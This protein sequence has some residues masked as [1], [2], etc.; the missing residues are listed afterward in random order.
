MNLVASATPRPWRPRRSTTSLE[1]VNPPLQVCLLCG[2][3]SR[4]MGR[5]KALMPHPDG[6]VWLTAIVDQLL[7]LELPIQVVSRYQAHA[8]QLADCSDVRVLLEP[9]PW[10]GPLNALAMVLPSTPGQALLVL[11]VDM[12]RLTTDIFRELILAWQIR[13]DRI[14]AAHDGE[15]LQPLLAVIPSGAPFQTALAEQL[16]AGQLRWLDWLD[17]L[18][19]QTVRLPSDA[20]LNANRPEDLAA[21]IP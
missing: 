8:D 16:N 2:G 3:D 20:L 9:P 6:G 1:V 4:R 7:P 11:P 10:R 12:P 15:R 21:L 19:H 13:P 5:D 17:R 14:A 18:P